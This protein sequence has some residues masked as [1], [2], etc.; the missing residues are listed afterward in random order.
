M[1]RVLKIRCLKME[2]FEKN[3]LSVLNKKLRDEKISGEFFFVKDY[4]PQNIKLYKE[5]RVRLFFKNM[6]KVVQVYEGKTVL[7]VQHEEV[8]HVYEEILMDFLYQAMFSVNIWNSIS[9]KLK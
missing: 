5:V 9:T 3:I 8:P 2:T 7:P 6:D 4:K 1:R